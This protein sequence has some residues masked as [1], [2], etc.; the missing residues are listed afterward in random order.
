MSLSNTN[1]TGNI[2]RNLRTPYR[3]ADTSDQALK[4]NS[5]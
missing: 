3:E 2:R 5:K 1:N 4:I